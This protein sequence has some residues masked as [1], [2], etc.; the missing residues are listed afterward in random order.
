M[1]AYLNILRPETAPDTRPT[2]VPEPPSKPRKKQGRPM[3]HWGPNMPSDV[4]MNMKIK[5][6][7]VLPWEHISCNDHCFKE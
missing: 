3:Q 6:T 2:L 4:S 7:N 5:K 1:Y